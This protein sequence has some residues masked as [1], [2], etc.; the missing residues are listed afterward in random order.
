MAKKDK[1]T[2]FKEYLAELES[3]NPAL[4]DILADEKVSAKLKDGVLARSE[5]SSQM[6]ALKAE[7]ESFATEV[8]E[9]RQKIQGWQNWYGEASQQLA[10][11][12]EENSK[13]KS[14]YG[15]LGTTHKPTGLTREELEK[16]Y[17]EE[18]RKRDTAN[19]LFADTLTDIKIDYKER[20]REKLPTDQVYKIA[21]ERGCDLQTAYNHFIHDRVEEQ[22]NKEVED[23]IAQA[24]KDAV[25]EYE[26][27]HNIPHVSSQSSVSH[28]LDI[29]DAPRSQRDRV[30]A[31]VSAFA[32]G[33]K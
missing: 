25:A 16:Y 11:A 7:R 17:Q 31:A 29:K 2:I 33:N 32:G 1:D 4:K 19:L 6:D 26:T 22:R 24:K 21:T 28:V 10:T 5:F 15:E 23:R 14:E 30:A 18:S 27:Q 12:L 9:A 13:Y 3:L 8:A 20:F